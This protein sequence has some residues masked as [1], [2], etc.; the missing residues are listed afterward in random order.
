MQHG[1][2]VAAHVGVDD[3]AALGPGGAEGDVHPAG[4]GH[5]CTGQGAY[6]EDDQCFLVL[7]VE[8]H[9]SFVVHDAVGH[10][11]AADIFMVFCVVLRGDLASGQ[12]GT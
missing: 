3:G 1:A 2:D 7:G 10:A 5:A 9:G 8:V 11:H 4:A 6:A 12:A